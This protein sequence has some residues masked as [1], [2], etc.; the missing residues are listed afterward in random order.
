MDD[1]NQL[2]YQISVLQDELRRQNAE[3]ERM[4]RALAEEQRRN[5]QAYEAQMRNGLDMRDKAVQQEY[6][7]LLEEYRRSTDKELNE[8][9]LQADA[10][11]R[12]LLDDVKRKEQEWQ[13]KNRRLEQLTAE[14]RKNAAD[15]NAVSGQEAENYMFEAGKLYKEIDKKPHEKFFPNRMKTLKEAL[16]EARA[17][18]KN[19]LNE[20]SAAV[21]ISARSGLDRLGYD[22]DEKFEEWERTYRIF[23]GKAELLTAR[24][25]DELADWYEFALGVKKKPGSMTAAEKS[26]AGKCVDHWTRGVYGNIRDRAAGYMAQINGAESSGLTE[27]LKSENSLSPEELEQSITDIDGMSADLGNA[28]ALCKERYRAAC[29]RADWGESIIDMLTDEHN[30]NWCED[31]SGFRAAVPDVLKKRDYRR[32]MEYQY[33]TDYPEADTREWLELVFENA[34]GAKIFI[35]IVPYEKGTRVENRL[36]M[37]IDYPGAE[38]IEYSRQIYS[39]ICACIGLEDDNGRIE[40]ASQVTQLTSNN[41]KTLRAAGQSIAE[42]LRR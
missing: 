12:R 14:L 23:K 28:S 1:I 21:A 40:F 25:T 42:K 24:L 9:R 35:Y 33:G 19:G 30:L 26:D 20:A 37:Y 39:H 18:R 32:Y 8:Q 17:L 2:Q 34:A 4:R 15:K 36:I 22:T 27:Y 29:Q 11:Y 38:N 7:R 41:D 5:L 10:N 3:A 13:E 16:A 6:S 31:E